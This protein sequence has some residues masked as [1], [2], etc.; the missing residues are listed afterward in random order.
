VQL[1]DQQVAE[2]I[3]L[4]RAMQTWVTAPMRT[5]SKSSVANRPLAE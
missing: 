3:A 2:R 5:R 4:G 1:L